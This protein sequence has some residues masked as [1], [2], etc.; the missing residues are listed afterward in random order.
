VDTYT[1]Y[2]GVTDSFGKI[3]FPLFEGSYKFLTEQYGLSF[4]SDAGVVCT[5]PTCTTALIT[6]LGSTY[7][8][9][10]TTIN[11]TYDDLNRLT[12]ADYNNG[13]YYHYEYD[14]AGNRLQQVSAFL[15][16][17]VTTAYTYDDANRL[18]TAGGQTYSFDA[19][20]NLLSDGT[21]T[22]TYDTANRLVGVATTATA[23]TYRYNGDGNR[24]QQS[25]NGVDTN[26]T[27]E[28]NSGLSQV[29][30]DGTNTYLYGMNRIGM[31][32]TTGNYLYEYDALG[33][34]RQ[35]ENIAGLTLAESY[36][37]YGNVILSSG[38]AG[39]YGYTGEEQSSNGLVYLRARTY[40]PLLGIFTSRDTWN[41]DVNLPMSYNWWMYTIGNPIKYTDPFGLYFWGPGETLLESSRHAIQTQ[42][43]SVR[44]QEIFM[45]GKVKYIHAE[46]PI[47]PGMILVDLLDSI[48]GEI[49]EIKPFADQLE[50]RAEMYYRVA[51]MNLASEG[52]L[53]IGR[54][55]TGSPY[56]W[57]CSPLVWVPGLSYPEE[58]YLGPDDTGEYDFYSGQTSEGV[59]SWWKYKRP[60][61]IEIPVIVP[62]NVT[63]QSKYSD[64]NVREN[65]APKKGNVAPQPAFS[66]P[67]SEEIIAPIMFIFGLALMAFGIPSA[68]SVL[69]TY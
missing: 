41:G 40:Q 39:I 13:M 19:N 69:Q 55:P 32:N 44:V 54:D 64:R 49:W 24:L 51:E 45:S 7:T 60:K 20:G 31:S 36:D 14:A 62:I 67:G 38:Q 46:Y 10:D 33:S 8:A 28:L 66:F 25:S 35:M 22:Y 52:E 68:T 23:V 29:L 61:P 21:Y 43:I 65:W 27:L 30:A 57:N 53:L 9:T 5:V 59:I 6:V 2:S 15:A 17:P 11:Y 58:V 56:N 63:N 47:P 26:Y 37:P 4:W 1:G 34:V 50:A 16:D 42:N 3:S 18:T 12:A 48:S